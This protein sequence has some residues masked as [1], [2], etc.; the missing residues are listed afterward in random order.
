M[1]PAIA[2]Q[3]DLAVSVQVNRN[4]IRWRKNRKKGTGGAVQGMMSHEGLWEGVP[5]GGSVESA[6]TLC[7]LTCTKDPGVKPV[8]KLVPW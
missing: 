6:P 5:V 3:Q 4:V 1:C 8:C 2:N 7:S